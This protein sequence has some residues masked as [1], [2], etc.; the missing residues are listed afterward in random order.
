[1]PGRRRGKRDVPELQWHGELRMKIRRIIPA[2]IPDILLSHLLRAST[3]GVGP[4]ATAY[5]FH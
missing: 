4:N 3:T 5:R 1:M 2:F